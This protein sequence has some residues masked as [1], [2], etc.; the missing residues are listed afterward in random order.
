MWPG[1]WGF[2]VYS[3]SYLLSPSCLNRP[4]GSPP[5][6]GKASCESRQNTGEKTGLT[7]ATASSLTSR[8]CESWLLNLGPWFSNKEQASREEHPGLY[9]GGVLVPS[10]PQ[11]PPAGEPGRVLPV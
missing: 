2:W 5:G 3:K 11:W 4:L 7:G 10:S 6:A 1:P 9:P 8:C